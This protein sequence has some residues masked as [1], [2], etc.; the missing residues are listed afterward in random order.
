MRRLVTSAVFVILA[1]NPAL[2]DQPAPPKAEEPPKCLVTKAGD[3]DVAPPAAVDYTAKLRGKKATPVV[4]KALC[5]SQ[6]VGVA[7][8]WGKANGLCAKPGTFKFTATLGTDTFANL[9]ATCP[10]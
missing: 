5:K 3:K 8:Q 1:A 4:A 10:K 9:N 2:A 6:A 7:A